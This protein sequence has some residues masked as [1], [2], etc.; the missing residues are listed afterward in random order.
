MQ[1]RSISGT[2]AMTTIPSMI[3]IPDPSQ[4]PTTES[5]FP[6]NLPPAARTPSPWS[7]TITSTSYQ[8]PSCLDRDTILQASNEGRLVCTPFAPQLRRVC[9]RKKSR[10][11]E[12][13][14]ISAGGRAGGSH[15]CAAWFFLCARRCRTLS[16]ASLYTATRT[17]PTP[18]H[19]VLR[20]SRPRCH[21][22]SSA[23]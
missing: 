14:M 4:S 1:Q 18:Y 20:M 6:T 11:R 9:S 21:G 19:L 3:F 7:K 22:R 17:H 8:T 12:R 15:F 16:F 2:T 5:S 10:G 13:G 23:T